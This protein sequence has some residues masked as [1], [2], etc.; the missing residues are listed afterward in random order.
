MS[1][2]TEG[3]QSLLREDEASDLYKETG[4][5][6]TFGDRA[7]QRGQVFVSLSQL[8]PQRSSLA[9]CCFYAILFSYVYGEN[10]RVDDN[11]P[12]NSE[13]MMWQRRVMQ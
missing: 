13:K 1:Y 2:N 6:E 9:K 3:L 5:I 7:L 4:G 12:S 10:Y 11:E 8:G